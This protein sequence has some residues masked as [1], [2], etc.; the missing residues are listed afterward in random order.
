M[1]AVVTVTTAPAAYVGTAPAPSLKGK[2]AKRHRTGAVSNMVDWRYFEVD[3]AL[4]CTLY[5]FKNRDD[6]ECR[7]PHH[8]YALG[9]GGISVVH[10]KGGTGGR[11]TGRLSGKGLVALAR[12]ATNFVTAYGFELKFSPVSSLVLGTET[13][14]AREMWIDGINDRIDAG[15][16]TSK[17][18]A[19]RTGK[20]H[21]T[22]D[23]NAALERVGL[24][25]A[26][27]SWSGIGVAITQVQPDSPAAKAGLQ[28]GDALVAVEDTACLS[29]VHAAR[30]LATTEGLE[31]AL[32]VAAGA[33]EKDVEDVEAV[34]VS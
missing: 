32:L 11:L 9:S 34:D 28:V 26:N 21:S 4:G 16:A 10:M 20:C 29:H 3:D 15:R 19:V 5:Q 30:L 25:C 1:T 12:L 24:T 14:E 27:L 22:G 6:M 17:F 18:V 31:L 23:A 2:L 33:A 8:C 13:E 7:K